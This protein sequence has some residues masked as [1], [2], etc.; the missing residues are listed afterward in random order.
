MLKQLSRLQRTRSLVI[1]VFAL[2]MGLSLIFF[3]APNRDSATA[4]PA[5]S[6][7]ALARVASDEITVSDLTRRKESVQQ[8]FGGQINLAMFGGDRRF[9]DAL[10]QERIAAREAA[11]LG[12]TASDA[13][14]AEAI[15]KQFSDASG[16]FVG[17]ER[18]KEI[19]N[20]QY[21][22]VT[23]F[24]EQIRAAIAGDKL[25]AFV[26][27]GVRVPDAEV[28]DDYVRQNTTFDLVY[29]PVGADQ[30]AKSINPSDDELRKY[31]EEHKNE[32]RINE[33]QKKI[34]YLFVDQNKVGGKLQIS[35]EDLRKEYDGLKP[36][37][38]QAGVRAQQIVLKVAR[39]ELDGE[40]RAKAEG[41]VQQARSK[42]ATVSEEAFAELARGNS[43]D[44]ATAKG[45][46]ALA[47]VVRKNP[48]KPDDPLQSTLTME[49]GQVSEPIKF[50][51]S[52]YIFRR[53]DAVEK[54]FEDAK[55][56]LLVS[57]RNRRAY[58][59]AA[60]I[61]K[62]A[63]DRLKETKDVEKVAA[64]FAAEANMSQSEMVRET[65]F[66]KPG[67]DVPDIGSSPQFESGIAPL[68]SAGDIGDRVSV[69]NGFAVP[70]LV[71]RR[72]PRVPEFVEVREQVVGRV[73]EER[74]KS[75]LE[76]AA[77][78]LAANADNAGELNAA[79]ERLGL[80]AEKADAYKLGTPL[81]Q[82]GTS[83]AADGAIYALKTGEV[84]KTPIKIGESW[85]VIGANK[86]TDAD[87]AEFAKQREQLTEQA[88]TERRSSMYEDYLTNA[89][90]RMERDGDIEVY[91]EVLAKLAANEP[92]AGA[93]FPGGAPFSIPGGQ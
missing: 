35:D 36:E 10:I 92:A 14:V 19:V 53:G 44:P 61:A 38:K 73:R 30:L 50:G 85:V 16:K 24:E 89:R 84:T 75:Q 32:F 7:E 88:L 62:R 17:T 81:G 1:V 21:G 52:Y 90:Q 57:L 11:R 27:A 48:N 67:D 56:E 42:G 41:L 86:R 70:L 68:N 39:P 82:A 15:R 4:S 66:V 47:G 78:D 20:S 64:E 60:D 93:P 45:G 28:Q 91:E 58:G 22:D 31:Y 6:R 8:R 23:K 74:A 29:V 33:P 46:G 77:R 72:D 63:A 37:N 49:P 87:L 5:T 26:T 34:R 71:E 18:Y 3:Y 51:T 65:P 25:R 12:L 69:K 13:E 9:L 79:A 43:E 40:V 83:P 59:G 76:Q 54:T 80:K 2:L 55:P